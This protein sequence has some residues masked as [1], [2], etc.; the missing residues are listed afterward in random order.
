MK[1]L[2][3]AGVA[4][5]LLN[6]SA[7][8]QRDEHRDET[9]GTPHWSRG[10]RLPEEFRGDRYIVSDWRGMHL[11]RPARGYHW[12]HV[13]DRYLL[14]GERNGEVRELRLEGEIHH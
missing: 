10:D 1:K 2:L 5:M 3:I 14:I 13:G 12:V 6:G 7:F 9:R 4:L 11:R 8:A